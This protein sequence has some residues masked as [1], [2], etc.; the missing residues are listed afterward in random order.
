MNPSDSSIVVSSEWLERRRSGRTVGT[1]P[2][3]GSRPAITTTR[4]EL[5]AAGRAAGGTSKFGKVLSPLKSVGKFAKG[6]PL[7]GTALAATDLIRMNKDNVGEKLDQL[8]VALLERLQEQ[9]LAVL[10]QEWEQPL[11]E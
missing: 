8:A 1:N 9:L 5:Y 10:F 6:L 4:S 11:V 7:L 3:R 2:T